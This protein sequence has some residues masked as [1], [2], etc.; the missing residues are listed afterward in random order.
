M[1]TDN[2]TIRPNPHLLEVNTR[3][4]LERLVKKYHRPLT[5]STV[6]DE[7]WQEYSRL[8][9]DIVWLM[10]IW[11]HSP[12]ALKAALTEP[13]LK[14]VYDRLL[15]GWNAGDIGGSPYAI[16]DYRLDPSLGTPGE[17]V[18]LR[19]NL[20]RNGLGL[21]IDFV[22]NHLAED[23]P[24]V[25]S[26]PGR[27]IHGSRDDFKAHPDWFFSPAPDIYVA[28][29][30]DPYFPPWTDTAQVNIFSPALRRAFI[31]QLIRISEIADGV[32]CDMAMLALNDIFEQV[33][34]K[35]IRNY[36]RPQTEF[37]DEAITTIKHNRPDFI[38]LG[39]VYWNLEKELLKIGFNFTYDKTLYDRLFSAGI[40]EII[41]HLIANEAHQTKL[42]RFIENHDEERAAAKFGREKSLAAATVIMTIPGLRFIY[43]GQIE[44]K[45][46]KQPV[47]MI[48]EPEEPVDAE[49]KSYYLQLLSVTNR[50]VFHYGEWHLLKTE[51]SPGKFHPHILSWYWQS[52]TETL[53]VLINYDSQETQATI[54]LP[55][56]TAARPENI[57]DLLTDKTF[58]LPP[59]ETGIT[60][61]L[62]PWQSLIFT[63]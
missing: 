18:K 51:T 34:G 11:H 36:P 49:I 48:R 15:P 56:T 16:Y 14:K 21:I 32:R 9:F 55:V 46:I 60:L 52:N 19:Q 53:V 17:L 41:K 42:V 20:N 35:I 50:P 10:G 40:P 29:G 2:V 7:E 3:P 33:W 43:E 59:S 58:M 61:V 63:Y 13:S 39:E 37:W 31:Q 6:P 45:T 5:L 26:Y 30:R 47:Q 22:P 8:G 38:F 4:F 12:A 24:W 57:R 1:T 25:L 27:F 23:H 62:K 28:H 44:G 54:R